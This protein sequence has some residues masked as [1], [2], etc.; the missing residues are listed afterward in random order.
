[1]RRW[2]PEVRTRPPAP[3]LGVVAEHRDAL[4]DAL[5][6]DRE[7]FPAARRIRDGRRS[8]SK[9]DTRQTAQ[10]CANMVHVPMRSG[11]RPSLPEIAAVLGCRH[12]SVIEQAERYLR[13][14][15]LAG[16][17]ERLRGLKPSGHRG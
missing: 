1:M 10:L 13:E 3:A 8:R 17:A 2:R 16:A 11:A 7:C 4:I 14:N 5:G 9:I 6:L 12:S 15:G